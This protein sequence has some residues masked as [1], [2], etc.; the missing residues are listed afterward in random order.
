MSIKDIQ[1]AP[2]LTGVNWVRESEHFPGPF[3]M[4]VA[5]RRQFG[6]VFISVLWRKRIVMS[7]ADSARTG[8]ERGYVHAQIPACRGCCGG[9][10][11][12]GGRPRRLILRGGRPRPHETARHADAND[13]QLWWNA[14][15]PDGDPGLHCRL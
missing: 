5:K 4:A 9:H 10:L 7:K 3:S 13:H 8:D 12:A 1:Q 2:G 15:D 14:R 6:R 11:D